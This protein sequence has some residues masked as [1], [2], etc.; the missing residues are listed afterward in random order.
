L[1][2]QR[3]WPPKSNHYRDGASGRPD[4]S[5]INKSLKDALL[6][7]PDH[8][9][10]QIQSQAALEVNPPA[11]KAIRWDHETGYATG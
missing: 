6:R 3:D 5:P 4:G 1:S 7:Y 10:V 11:E 9:N 2:E 8:L